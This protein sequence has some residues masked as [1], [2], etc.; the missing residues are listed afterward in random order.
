MSYFFLLRCHYVSFLVH[1]ACFGYHVLVKPYFICIASSWLV[2]VAECISTYLFYWILSII[3]YSRS[4]LIQTS[5]IST[6]V[7]APP[8]RMCM[9][10][11]CKRNHVN[12]IVYILVCY[13]FLVPY[14]MVKLYSHC[15][16]FTYPDKFTYLNSV[17]SNFGQMSCNGGSAC[18][19]SAVYISFVKFYCWM[20]Y[21]SIGKLFVPFILQ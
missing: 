19:A 2:T 6:T 14:D 8:P 17:I 3:K 15:Y 13:V 5:I 10:I 4:S 18:T 9:C 11:T 21:I 7:P 12:N 20:W 1:I 16:D